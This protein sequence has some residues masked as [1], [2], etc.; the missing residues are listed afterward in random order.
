[1][2]IKPMANTPL[3]VR[4]KGHNGDQERIQFSSL[5]SLKNFPI[6]VIRYFWFRLLGLSGMV[7]SISPAVSAGRR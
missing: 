6:A 1:M 2:K 5:S 3:E 4:I 7:I